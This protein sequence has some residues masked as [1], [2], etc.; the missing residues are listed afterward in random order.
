VALLMGALFCATDRKGRHSGCHQVLGPQRPGHIEVSAVETEDAAVFRV[1]DTGR[2]IAEEDMD[3]LFQPF[4][5]AGL[6]D[7]PGEGMGPAFVRMLLHRLG[8]RIECHS[9]P[10]VGTT[11]SFLLPRMS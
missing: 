1:R 3:K 5:R 6:Q 7:V 11:F 10:G 4:R 8:G 9:Q 2:G